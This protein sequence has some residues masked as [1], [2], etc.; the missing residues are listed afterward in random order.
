MSDPETY[1]RV[2]FETRH[3]D[4]E[5]YGNTETEAMNA[6]EHAWN[7]WRKRCA[8]TDDISQMDTWEYLKDDVSML[9]FHMGQAFMD[10]DSWVTK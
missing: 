3:F 7:K 10:R 1:F 6:L 5:A 8:E 9:E 4:F 2:S